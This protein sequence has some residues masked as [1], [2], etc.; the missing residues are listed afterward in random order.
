M[1]ACIV[2]CSDS[3]FSSWQIF[4]STVRGL[5]RFKTRGVFQMSTMV[6]LGIGFQ[7]KSLWLVQV[8]N[9]TRRWAFAL[10]LR[11]TGI[12]KFQLATR[13]CESEKTSCHAIL[14]HLYEPTIDV[15][16]TISFKI[17][18]S[19]NR[20][21]KTR[22]SFKIFPQFWLAKSIRIICYSQL[23]TTKFGRILCLTRKW[24]KMHPA[25]G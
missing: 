3:E 21:N 14:K 25:T 9:L 22:Y 18:L 13:R 12:Y 15:I 19:G 5:T 16:L 20:D 4:N 7:F 11:N 6:N 23:L 1:R 17:I 8:L 2:R 10:R 24:S